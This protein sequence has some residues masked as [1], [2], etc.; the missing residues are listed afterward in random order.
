M[1][2][3]PRGAVLLLVD[4]QRGFD[5]PS[6]GRRNNPGAEENLLRLLEAWRGSNRPVIHVRHCSSEPDSTLRRER[7]GC[8]LKSGFEPRP[9]EP[10]LEKQVNSAFIGT[11]LSDLLRS[12]GCEALVIGGLT[13][14]HC[15]ST[16]ARMA[17]NLGFGTFVIADGTAT[18][19][20]VGPDGAHHDAQL[21]HDTALASLH[22][23]F[24]TIVDTPE[25]I[26]ALASSDSA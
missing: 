13:T 16:T 17:G 20:R 12:N 22:G 11:E 15:I 25:L 4:L 24:A 5:D 9:G 26:E 6:W 8:A 3:I 2:R 7:P 23:E 14:D 10:L 21:M 19:D 1:I 18:F